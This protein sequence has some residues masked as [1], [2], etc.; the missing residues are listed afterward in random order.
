MV[1]CGRLGQGPAVER[2]VATLG[3][4]NPGAEEVAGAEEGGAAVAGL[5]CSRLELAGAD[6]T[7]TGSQDFE[8]PASAGLDG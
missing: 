3:V 1:Q 2:A 4:D 7:A 8:Q 6:G 5:V